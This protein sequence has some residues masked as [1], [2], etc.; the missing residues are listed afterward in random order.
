[1]WADVSVEFIRANRLGNRFQNSTC[2]ILHAL[3]AYPDEGDRA[4][5]V[6]RS[7]LKNRE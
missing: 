2:V 4:R 6:A 3:G 5:L 7:L 1:M